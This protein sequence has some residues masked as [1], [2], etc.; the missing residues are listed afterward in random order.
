MINKVTNKTTTFTSKEDAL[1]KTLDKSQKVL[2]GFV[3][4]QENLKV[5]RFAQDVSTNWIPKVVFTRSLPDFAEMTFLEYTESALFYFAPEIFGKFFRKNLTKF[6]PQELRK[7]VD[8]KIPKSAEK[9]LADKTLEKDG[10]AKRALTTK[11]AIILA[12]TSIPASEYALSFAKNLFTLKLFKKSDFNNIVNL[13]KEQVE[14]KEHQD[15][16]RNSAYSHIKN[17]GLL[18]LGGLGASIV[19]A[20]YGH[21][22]EALQKLSSLILQPGA[23]IANGFKKIGLHS[24]KVEKFLKKYITPDF[25]EKDGKLTLSKG[26]LLVSTVSGFCGYSSAGKDRG[27]LDQLEVWTRV[28]IVVFYTV[29]GSSLFDGA[30]K[31]ILHNKKDKDGNRIYE[32]LINKGADDKLTVP[33]RAELPDIAKKI[34]KEK[35]SSVEKEFNNLLKKKAFI[36]FVPYAFALV[37]MGFLLAGINRFWTQ[38]RYNKMKKQEQTNASAGIKTDQKEIQFKNLLQ[39]TKSNAFKNFGK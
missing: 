29:F 7:A 36:T 35:G 2:N 18:S 19:F 31:R 38:Y 16:V 32:H 8:A 20:K 1:F 22:S 37:F 9:I 6:T 21:K 13:N 5:T 17:A 10:I 24:D 15:K 33:T 3:K 26:Q 23:H 4:S 27:K 34:A 12:C 14:N 30:F 39:P 28:P 25:N 11:A